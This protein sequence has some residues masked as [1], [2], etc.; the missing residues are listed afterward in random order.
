[1][2]SVSALGLLHSLS[3]G[4]VT[5]DELGLADVGGLGS[6]DGLLNNSYIVS[7]NLVHLKSDGI[8]TLNDAFELVYLAEFVEGN[9][10]GIVE[11]DEV[12]ELLVGGKGGRVVGDSLL[13]AFIASKCKD[14]L[15]K[16]SVVISAVTS[17]G[18]HLSNGKF[19]GIGDT[20]IKASRGA[21]S[22]GGVALQV[23]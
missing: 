16:D 17:I 7:V 13:E 23:G 2:G 4:V 12:I 15:V 14:V 9:L 5:L 20:G 11:D 3:D 21:L 22:S 1:M 18:H 8:V 6:S 19:D 10:V